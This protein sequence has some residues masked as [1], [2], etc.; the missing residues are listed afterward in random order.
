MSPRTIRVSLQSNTVKLTGCGSDL[1]FL[2]R[3]VRTNK[4]G[5]IEFYEIELKACRWA[6]TEL[7]LEIAKMQERDRER[8]RGEQDLLQHEIYPL[9][10]DIK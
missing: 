7:V 1:K 8:I 3:A 2:V 6:I 9:I 5:N 4:R 10:K